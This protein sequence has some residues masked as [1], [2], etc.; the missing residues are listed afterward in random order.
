[1]PSWVSSVFVCPGSPGRAHRFWCYRR[2]VVLVVPHTAAVGLGM[3]ENTPWLLF[4]RIFL[5]TYCLWGFSPVLLHL[6]VLAVS[7]T[8]GDNKS[9][10]FSIC[11]VN[12]FLLLSVINSFIFHWLPTFLLLRDQVNNSFTFPL[13]LP[14]CFLS[15]SHIFPQPSL[16]YIKAIQPF[17]SLFISSLLHSP[18]HFN[19]HSL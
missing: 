5:W 2:A 19:C 14:S 15:L 4:F 6:M 16:L 11:H 3:L 8:S 17:Q 18:H 12:F 9:P 1:M 7:T 13:P 10:D